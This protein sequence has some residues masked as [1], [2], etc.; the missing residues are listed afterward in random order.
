MNLK[1]LKNAFIIIIIILIIIG[2]YIIYIKDNNPQNVSNSKNKETVISKNISIGITKFDTINPIL[3]KSLEIQYITKLIYEPLINITQDFNT[4]PSLAEEW[5][6]LD[7]L[8]Y[9]VKISDEKKWQNGDN[10]KVDDIEFTINTIKNSNSVYGENVEKINKIEK[11]NDNTLKIILSEPVQFFEYLL[12]FPIVQEKTYNSEIPIGTGEYQISKITEGKIEIKGA[13]QTI[14]VVIYNSVSE[15]YNNF[16]RENVDLILTT[17]TN[18]EEYIGNIGF[19]ETL[20]TGREFYYISCENIKDIQLRNFI[21]KHINKEKIVYDLYNKKYKI[22]EFPLEYGSFL[23][24]ENNIE[25]ENTNT[26]EVRLTLSIKPDEETKKIAESIKEQL[27]EENIN[28]TMQNYVNSKAD[29]ILKKQT[30]PI[31]PD[32]S[33]YFN[34]EETKEE[35]LKISNI[36]NK[37]I[38]KQEYDEIIEKYYEEKPFISLYFNNYIILHNSKLKG[39]FSGNWYNIFYNIDTWYKIL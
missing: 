19:E 16:T 4:E 34:N 13:E 35:I 18:Y 27:K 7:E 23:N 30:V 9:I 10:V 37:A 1:Y 29:M 24:K 11:V 8:T 25:E 26:K 2:I 6:K 20:I 33:I 3:T 5:S 28:I 39:D 17:K 15:L 14:K 38:L 21:D 32:I 22:A 12:C 31:I 36:E